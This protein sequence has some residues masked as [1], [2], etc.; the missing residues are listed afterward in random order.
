MR[1]EYYEENQNARVFLSWA[2]ASGSIPQPPPPVAT[3]EPQPGHQDD[4]WRGEYFTNVDFAGSPDFVRHDSEIDF[5]WGYGG[6][7]S[8]FPVDWFGVRWTR[9][10][11]FPEGRAR[12]TT[13]VDDG[14]RI[15][16][17]G[18]L[19]LEKWFAQERKRY[20]VDVNMSRGQH[21]IV[22]EYMERTQLASVQLR[23][24]TPQEQ[25]PPIGNIIT[26][27][28]PQPENYAWIKLYRLDGNNNW[29][30][31][32]RGI[33]SIEPSGFLKIDGLPVDQNRFGG[34]GEPYRVEM[35]V[36]GNVTLS[37]GNFQAGEPEFRV[38]AFA[39]NYTPWGCSR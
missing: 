15:F 23:I 38:R 35:W 39:D 28:P 20:T 6:P 1:L 32:G 36:N 5:D 12:F 7:R 16:V 3:V 13:E 27:A 21:T 24:A 2:P 31:I 19:V 25:R 30:S 17:D 9:T 37:T 26:C 8:G 18:N 34:A 29:Y 33:G 22:L 14:V 4:K 10:M 11:W